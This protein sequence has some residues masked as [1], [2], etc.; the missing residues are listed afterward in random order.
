VILDRQASAAQGVERN[1]RMA[2]QKSAKNG[3]SPSLGLSFGTLRASRG[4]PTLERRRVLARTQADFC[5]LPAASPRANF[6]KSFISRL[7]TRITCGAPI[8][9]INTCR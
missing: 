6:G 4:T 9:P 7:I 3:A 5:F 1:L 8:A 2:T